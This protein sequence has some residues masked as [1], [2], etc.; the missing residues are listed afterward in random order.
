MLRRNLELPGQR[1]IIN[2]WGA[3]TWGPV[4]NEMGVALGHP[5]SISRR[6][7]GQP[8]IVNGGQV[9]IQSGRVLDS[10][11]N[12]VLNLGLIPRLAPRLLLCR[13]VFLHTLGTV[14][15]ISK[16]YTGIIV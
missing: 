9:R 10:R 12:P 1:I 15:Y 13:H 3:H 11:L 8:G 16:Q 7:K 14:L 2:V 4:S 6:I 5:R